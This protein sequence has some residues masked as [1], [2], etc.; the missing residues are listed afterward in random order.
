MK[1]LDARAA[2]IA[3]NT[4]ARAPSG[5]DPTAAA[6]DVGVPADA[7]SMI[8][9]RM[10]EG[11]VA[12]H[13]DAGS[14]P[15]SRITGSMQ[16][17]APP[18]PERG[19][20]A[21][22][23]VIGRIEARQAAT[24]GTAVSASSS[25]ELPR[26][27]ELRAE[28]AMQIAPSGT[29]VETLEAPDAFSRVVSAHTAP[30]V[31]LAKEMAYEYA[32]LPTREPGI[33]PAGS[34][35]GD[36]PEEGIALAMVVNG[37]TI[38]RVVAPIPVHMGAG[39][40]TIELM[41]EMPAA[42]QAA[43][44]ELV[45]DG[46]V[47]ARTEGGFAA[48]VP[49]DALLE[50]GIDEVSVFA[51][52]QAATLAVETPLATDTQASARL[53]GLLNLPAG[54]SVM[55]STEAMPP[56]AVS[57]TPA[58]TVAFQAVPIERDQLIGQLIQAVRVARHHESTEI[59]VRLKPEFLGRLSIRVLADDHGMRVEIRAEN[60][61]VRQVMQDNLADLEQRLSEKGLA[62]EQFNVFAETGSDAHRQLD[63][64]HDAPVTGREAERETSE[65]TSPQEARP[66]G[67]A[68]IDY[69]A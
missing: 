42:A 36:A 21:I 46:Q 33:A 10:R 53:E 60:E 51:R 9:R 29:A 57:E 16:S 64:S 47:A 43:R 52:A 37:R 4:H 44:I 22:R 19:A 62:F 17:H 49:A 38:D 59:V 40:E 3:Q 7:F 6:A 63:G 8:F 14:P 18:A 34:F 65:A 2:V 45:G 61:L 15:Q 67:S 24:A 23:A 20:P 28:V 35:M 39:V 31:P 48:A 50:L 55:T 27:A 54:Q 25:A 13:S 1:N 56:L 58:Q 32:P 41:G 11:I 68:V 69:L 26:V 66:A 5:R 30:L 12:A